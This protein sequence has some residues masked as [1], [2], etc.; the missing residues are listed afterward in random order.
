MNPQTL[1]KLTLY[2]NNPELIKEISNQELADLVVVVLGAV[3]QIEN[4]IKDGRL[5]GFTPRPDKEYL[6]IDTARKMLSKAVNDMV[7][8]YDVEM[9]AKGSA[10]ESQVQAAIDRIRDGEDGIVSDE[11]IQRAAEIAFSLIEMPDFEKLVETALTSSSYAVRDSLELIQEEEQKLEMTAVK[12]LLKT[13]E[14][15][16]SEITKSKGVAGGGIGKNTVLQLI[17]ENGSSLPDQTG[18][19]GK[20]LTTDG[21]DASWATLAGGGDMAKAVYDTNDDGIVDEA[22]VITSQGALATQDTITESQISDLKNYEIKAVANGSLTAAN[23]TFYVCVSSSTFTDPT[24]TEG[25]GYAVL[26]RNGTATIGGTGYSTA[27]TIIHRTFH[28]GAW[29]N[30]VYQ[31]TTQLSSTYQPLDSDLT[32]IAAANNGSVLAATTASFTTADETK[33]DGIEASADVTDTANVTAA[34]A[35]MDS[36]VT[37]LAGI[38]SLVTSTLQVKPSEGAF[39][40]GDKTKLDGIET[41]ADVTDATNVSAAG[42]PIISSGAGAPAS[43][44]TKVGDIYIDTTND[45]AYI[46]VGTASSADW[47]KSNDGAGGGISDGDKGD[48]TVSSSGAVWTIDN[49]VVTE[50]KTSASVQTSLGLADT[51]LQSYTETD[52]VVGAISGIVK[53]NGAG[54]ISAAVAD[55]DYL[56]PSTAS[57]TYAPIASPTLTG[58]TTVVRLDYDRAI[59]GVNAIGNL[60][61]TETFDWSAYTNFTG[62]L[63]ANT[64]LSFSNAVSGQRITLYLSYDGSAQRTIAWG[65]TIKWGGGSAPT[66]PDTAGQVLAVTITYVGTTYYGSFET[67]S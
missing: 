7:S 27:G 1:K 65:S 13:I 9:R 11:E 39:V 10:L 38:K 41:G 51:A 26:V 64:T 42:A 49:G 62:T 37:D 63:D 34:G 30:Y 8:N 36:E 66:G 35:L 40:D 21:T 54:T 23:D 5:D 58:T 47:E 52:P 50:A 18:N 46:A 28:S 56:T 20:F 55:T 16:R 4:A 53:A 29:A 57:S 22:A 33:L 14:E 6:S 45:D 2:K 19:N 67:L 15:L 48:I 44:P 24:P 12:D 31:D 59:G 60:G 32:T 3:N 61:A 17:A 43:T 25:E